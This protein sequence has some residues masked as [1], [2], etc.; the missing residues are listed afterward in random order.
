MATTEMNRF[1]QHL[2][3]AC[4]RDGG[5][6]TDGELLT[7]FLS[8]RADDALA[9]LMRRHGPMVW[10]VCC[11][12]LR[13]HQDA[14]DA[15]QATFL[16][17]VQ[18]AATLPDKEM[19]GNW[20]YGVAHQT[21]V[22][23]RA[24]AAKRS[25]RE[26]QVTVMPEPIPTD[27]FLGNDLPLVLDE[28]LSR[29]PDKYRVLIVLCDLDG[30]T[31]KE[32][33]RQLGVPEGT[34]ASRLAT[35]RTMLAKRVARRGV[36]VCGGSLGA[37]LSQQAASACVPAAVCVSTIKAATLIA[38]GQAVAG[39]ISPTVAALMTGVTKA[40]C[41]MKI[42]SALAVLL[43]V[44]LV[45]GTSGLG[46]GLLNYRSQAAEE[47][48]RE[49]KNEEKLKN[50]KPESKPLRVSA[51][52]IFARFTDDE[53]R[54][55]L[56]SVALSPD[57]KTLAT[58]VDFDNSIRLL[59]VTDQVEQAKLVGH[60]DMV[61]SVAFSPDGKT[62]ATGSYDKSVRL[63]NVSTGK[64]TATLEG[65]TDIVRC[66]VFSP[67]GSTLAAGGHDQMIRLWDVKTLK[68]KTLF[69]G[70]KGI[71]FSLAF[72]RNGKL[73]IS[74]SKD[75][76]VRLW[77]L[78]GEKGIE[79]PGHKGAV[80]ALAFGSGDVFASGDENGNIILWDVKNGK[81]AEL[82][83]QTSIVTT[84][85][86]S[87]DGQYLVSGSFDDRVVRFWNIQTKSKMFHPLG[88]YQ[89][90][91]IQAVYGLAYRPDGKGVFCG[92]SDGTVRLL[93]FEDN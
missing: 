30:L 58:S 22:R 24:M 41:M 66:V 77:D 79:L 20:L 73:L 17:L 4:G 78:A 48:K 90:V 38:A 50:E 60:T 85:T 76:T 65:P 61:V 71:V 64:V 81:T 87:P 16:V 26:R 70:H 89:G 86:F 84:M 7:R 46:M 2:L 54:V 52:Q 5:G 18:K 29:L 11:R 40:M 33:A 23:M 32:V 39:A 88:S 91:P 37:V 44:G 6:M 83:G 68:E 3:A 42:K 31:R 10:G 9:A 28:E 1:I 57:G 75:K 67:D 51:E 21:A 34:V 43:A 35:A 82:S 59:R 15:F 47:T 63:W 12:L 8:N 27:Q 13:S 62:L 93:K 53:G 45:C 36:V 25:V 74:G 49:A 80:T 55:A 14:E 19:V 92:T 56:R 72:A 69:K